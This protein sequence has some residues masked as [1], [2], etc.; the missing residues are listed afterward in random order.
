MCDFCEDEELSSDLEHLQDN[1]Y[2]YEHE[3]QIEVNLQG[4]QDGLLSTY[5]MPIRINNLDGFMNQ[6]F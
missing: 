4:D 1:E 6:N 5:Q 2:P 3:Y